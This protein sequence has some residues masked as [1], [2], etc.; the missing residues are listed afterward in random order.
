MQKKAKCVILLLGIMMQCLHSSLGHEPVCTCAYHLAC[1]A[2]PM[3]CHTYDR[4]NSLTPPYG[5]Y[6]IIVLCNAGSLEMYYI[7]AHVP[8]NNI[9]NKN[10]RNNSSY[11]SARSANQSDIRR[12]C[13]GKRHGDSI[14]ADFWRHLHQIQLIQ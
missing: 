1:H 14:E 8:T 6:R 11:L 13:C 2:Q 12:L 9:K 7:S 5:Q 3:R 10:K 4:L